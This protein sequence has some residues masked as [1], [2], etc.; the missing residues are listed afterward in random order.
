MNR[1]K[2]KEFL[3]WGDT[4]NTVAVMIIRQ[5]A[6]REFK[7]VLLTCDG[8]YNLG[9]EIGPR[10]VKEYLDT[11]KWNQPGTPVPE[12]MRGQAL[13]DWIQS[14]IKHPNEVTQG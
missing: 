8:K 9:M 3:E 13:L 14:Q 6:E 1:D 5:S 4:D 7:S 11:H 12:G 2:L 10:T